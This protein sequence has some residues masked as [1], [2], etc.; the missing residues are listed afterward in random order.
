M[1]YNTVAITLHPSP[2]ARQYLQR[3]GMTSDPPPPQPELP[4][5]PPTEPTPEPSPEENDPYYGGTLGAGIDWSDPNS[6][7]APYYLTV[8]GI[9][10]F[11]VAGLAFL[12]LST[13]PLLHTDF[14]AHL[15]YGEWIT[16]NGKL[17]DHEPLCEFTDKAAPMFDGMW[18]SQ[19]AYHGLFRFGAA[20]APGDDARRFAGS[21]EVIRLTHLLA[22]V[23]VVV[24][25]GI[26][27]RRRS[28][29]VLW[30][31]GGMVFLIAPIVGVQLDIQRPQA[32]AMVC[33]AA[34]LCG[35]SRPV[36]SRRAVVWVPLL[37]VLWANL[38]G[39]FVVGFGLLG[40]VLAGRGIDLVRAEGWR[41]A[42]RD[43]ATRRLGLALGLSLALVAIL[44]PYGP[45]LYINVIKFGGSPNLRTVAEWQPLNFS[46]PF[47]G[48]W[49]YLAGLVV[50]GLTQLV[51]PRPL[52]TTELL[53]VLAFG[54]WPLF[55]QRAMAWWPPLIPWLIAPHWVAA[56]ER[57]G[58]VRKRDTP[59]FRKTVLAVLIFG[60]MVL[61]SPAVAW[62]K[63][64]NPLPATTSLHRGTPRDIAAALKGETPADPERVKALIEIVRS[65][66][67]GKFK[68]RIFASEIQGEYLLW[69]LPPEAPVM[70]FN[71]SQLF[72]VDYWRECLT[73]LT[74]SPG[75]WEILDRRRPDLIVV[76]ADPRPESLCGVLRSHPD[77]RVALDE[78]NAVGRSPFSRVFVAVRKPNSKGAQ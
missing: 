31:V 16:A 26:A 44:N 21:V 39:S 54:L 49:G 30:A 34:L 57:W 25:L 9:S 69:A 33:F 56:S 73:V 78:A 11:I 1:S 43:T 35:L 13:A 20:I 77:W 72:G 70:M 37:M 45:S 23:S 60:L 5:P 27:Y 71:H 28:D 76:E 68:G 48:H 32:F 63:T 15:K 66:Y 46:A 4:A 3:A 53:L 50:I 41:A 62:I 67:G 12:L 65:E 64:G 52:S 17:P 19:V 38:H 6:P 40:I 42:W 7:L 14:W 18:L 75:W 47:G 2:D 59:N 36:L 8:A 22:G 61:I 51:S 29:S 74:A 24:L 55:Q 10:A 58:M